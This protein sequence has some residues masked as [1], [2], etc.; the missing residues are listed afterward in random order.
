M[1]KM[2]QKW[3]KMKVAEGSAWGSGMV[4][5]LKL[6]PRANDFALRWSTLSLIYCIKGNSICWS[7]FDKGISLYHIEYQDLASVEYNLLCEVI[8][9]RLWISLS[10]VSKTRHRGWRHAHQ[11]GLVHFLG[12]WVS[13]VTVVWWV[14]SN[15]N[16][17]GVVG[18]RRGCTWWWEER[19]RLQHT[20]MVDHETGVQNAAQKNKMRNKLKNRKSMKNE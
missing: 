15:V 13:R 1:A 17:G 10:K 12:I 2:D 11:V 3:R 5:A 14:G 9:T 4:A 16:V 18:R 7:L 6:C 19:M 20:A 8:Y